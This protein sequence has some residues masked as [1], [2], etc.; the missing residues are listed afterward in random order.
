[1]G[2]VNAVPITMTYLSKLIKNSILNLHQ[3]TNLAENKS[4]V[5]SVNKRQT[6]LTASKSRSI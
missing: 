5:I 6:N 2:D 1:M 4:N 3:A